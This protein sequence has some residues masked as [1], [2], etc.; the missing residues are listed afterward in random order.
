VLLGALGVCG[1][2]LFLAAGLWYADRVAGELPRVAVGATLDEVAVEADDELS[3]VPRNFLIVGA[4]SVSTLPEDDPLRADRSDIQLLT[5][6]MMIARIDPAAEA[7]H[8]LSIPRDLFV[9]IAGAGY[10]ERINAALAIGG[11]DTLIRSIQDEL[12]IPIH[13][14]VEAD[15]NGFRKV[16]EA[17]DGVPLYIPFPMRD[18]ASG[19]VQTEPGCHRLAPDDALKYVRSRAMEGLIDGD[20]GWEY[21]DLTPDLGR[22]SRQQDF[23]E[24]ALQ[25]AIAKGGLRNP[26]ASLD[27]LD[28]AIDAVT[29]DDIISRRDLLDLGT[30]FETFQSGSL[31]TYT[32]P[33][34][35]AD[36]GTEDA[37]KN[38]LILADP[39]AQSILDVFR[40]S[41]TAADAASGVR[42]RVLNGTGESGLASQVGLDLGTVGFD[43]VGRG[44]AKS[45]EN[46]NSVVRYVEGQAEAAAVIAA[47]LGESEGS[48]GSVRLTMVDELDS[49][50]VEIVVGES[51]VAVDLDVDLQ[52]LVDAAAVAADLALADGEGQAD[53]DDSGAE[54]TAPE[55]EPTATPVPAC[56]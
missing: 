33:V 50:D 15:F 56:A 11:S 2:S 3:T 27:L 7:A 53:A 16:V 4:D 39:E 8:L 14:Y 12:G 52:P 42:V 5:D 46:P 28:S 17:L 23:M 21:L 38:V 49:A 30:Q 13:H 44:D 29:L 55:P 43:V 10:D 32:L 54:A 47:A 36:V 24:A 34:F 20:V 9:P 41:G 22:I 37:P 51:F 48:A 31:Q 18:A 40:G 45:F 1:G 19:F 26:Q 25:R 6:T 35:D